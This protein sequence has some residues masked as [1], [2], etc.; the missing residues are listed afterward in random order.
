MRAKG[1]KTVTNDLPCS[2]AWIQY[3]ACMIAKDQ[4]PCE[5]AL[6]SLALVEMQNHGANRAR[7]AQAV[8]A[9]RTER[10]WLTKGNQTIR[11]IARGLPHDIYSSSYK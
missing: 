1:R 2:G 9:T 6:C 10:V 11:Q 5:V 7:R 3:A 8:Y 4:S